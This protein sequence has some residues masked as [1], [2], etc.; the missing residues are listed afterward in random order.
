MSDNLD[1]LGKA[2][3]YASDCPTGAGSSCTSDLDS[4]TRARVAGDPKS[5]GMLTS[6]NTIMAADWST[7]KVPEWC[8][9]DTLQ[10]WLA[11]P[12]HDPGT[13]LGPLPTFASVERAMRGKLGLSPSSG[14]L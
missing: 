8:G 13:T 11:T 6:G 14:T 7:L 9:N 2:S 3:G 12:G 1:P 10:Q 4:N 5:L